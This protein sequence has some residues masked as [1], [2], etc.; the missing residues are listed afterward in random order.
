[1]ESDALFPGPAT[2]PIHTTRTGSTDDPTAANLRAVLSS[3]GETL[4][5]W[6]MASDRITWGANAATTLRVPDLGQIATGR[7]YAYRV[8]QD[9]GVP[10]YDAVTRGRERDTGHGVPFRTTYALR[11]EGGE[12]VWI[13]D[14][15]RWFAGSGGRPARVHGVVRVVSAPSEGRSTGPFGDPLTGALSRGQLSDIL[16]DEITQ[17]RRK[18]T[19]FA[20]MLVGI[21]NLSMFNESYGFDVSDELIAGIAARIRRVMRRGDALARYAGS[22]LAVVLMGCAE[23]QLGVAARRFID[24]VRAAPIDTAAGPIAVQVRIGGILLPRNGQTAAEAMQHAEEALADAKA[25]PTQSFVA[26]IPDRRREQRR[27]NNR[28]FTDEIVS[29][30]NERRVLVARQAVVHARSRAVA[31]DEALVRIR[32]HDGSLMTAAQIVPMVEKLGFVG[33]LDLRV[34][35]IAVASLAAEPA[36]SMSLNVSSVTLRLP[37]WMDSLAAQLAARPDVA[38]RLIV[39]VTETSIIDDLEQ[40]RRV[41]AGMKELGARVAIDDFGAG[42]TSFRHL[43]D[44]GIDMVKI[45]GAF[46]QNLGRSNDDRFFVKTLLDLARHLEVEVVAEWVKDEE[47]AVLLRDW[48]VDYLQGE[49]FGIAEPFIDPGAAAQAL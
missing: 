7:A 6:D 30:L 46:V 26:F 36:A 22:K 5:D 44:L 25:S 49:L 4:Y 23:E 13:E 21:E 27:Q 37:E 29:A 24:A 32:R 48:G 14:T 12:P 34:L 11:V 38:R 8:L 31:F 17:A 3:I 43:R 10:R 28:R 35:E 15:G 42:H 45:D 47:T 1:M 33:L 16:N 9:S 20:M 39:E 18:H 40:T 41:I 2:P 19:S